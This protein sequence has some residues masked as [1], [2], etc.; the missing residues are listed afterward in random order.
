VTQLSYDGFILALR[1]RGAGVPMLL[2][3]RIRLVE[4]VVRVVPA[5][6]AGASP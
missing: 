5:T 1:R 2:D 6:C 3:M 4:P